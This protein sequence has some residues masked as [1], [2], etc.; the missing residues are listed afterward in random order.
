MLNIRCPVTFLSWPPF[1]Y[2]SGKKISLLCKRLNN[3]CWILMLHSKKFFQS[4]LLFLIFKNTILKRKGLSLYQKL[5][6][7][8]LRIKLS[9]QIISTTSIE[10]VW[11]ISLN[12]IKKHCLYNFIFIKEK[13]YICINS[14]RKINWE[15]KGRKMNLLGSKICIEQI[16]YHIT[17][18]TMA[19]TQ[20]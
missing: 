17:H 16:Q 3:G 2:F 20:W 12:N 11:S 15:T 5:A 6:M 8:Y 13:L 18:V 19:S 1:F 7:S 9:F 4:L 14:F 10:S